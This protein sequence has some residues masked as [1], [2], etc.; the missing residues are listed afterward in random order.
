MT[1]AAGAAGGISGTVTAAAGGARLRGVH[2]EVFAGSGD[3]AGSADTGADGTY[4]V[5]GL[6]PAAPG[7]SVCFDGRSAAGGSSSTGYA[8]QCYQNLPWDGGDPAPDAAPVPVTAGR[9]TPGVDAALD[10]AGL[11]GVS[12]TVT[13]AAGGGRL[14]GVR[15]WAYTGRGGDAGSAV[16]GADGTYRV[17]GLAPP[18][19]GYRV[20]FDASDATGGSSITGYLSQC[21][22]NVPWAG[23]FTPAPGAAPVPVTAG[24][25]TPAIDAALDTAGGISGTVTAAAGGARL[26]G[27][28]VRVYSGSGDGEGSAVTGADGTYRV[29]RLAPA[30]PGYR[31]CF[32]ASDVAGGSSIT[33][34]LSQCYRN[35]PWAGGSPAP[36]AAPVPVTAGRLTPAVDAA[37]GAAGGVSGTVTAAAGGARLSGVRVEVY[38]SSGD[39]E[40][41]AATGPDGTYEVTG[42]A[43]VA[44]GYRV[45]FDASYA[46]GGSSSA[47]YFS[48]CYRDVPWAGGYS[49][50][51]GAA[52]VPVTGGRLTTVDAALNA[53][54]GISGTVT[55]AAGGARLSGVDVEVFA[56]SGDAAGSADTGADGTYEVTGLAP[57][58]PGYR[59]CF[60]ARFAAGGS[61][62]A[63]YLSQCYRN[64]PW[65]GG[66]PAPGAAPVPVTA[67]R[68]TP[69]VDA[70]LN[71]AGKGGISGTVTAAAGGARLS[72][73][74]V[75]VFT[76]SG[77]D[78][79]SAV[80]GADGTY[81]VTGLPTAT[82]GYRVCFD[83]S[84]ATGGSSHLG[85]ASQCYR[86]VPWDINVPGD[87]DS[88]A[89]GAAPVPVTAGRLAPAVDAA[90]GAAGGISGT[91][92]AAAGGARLNGVIVDVYTSSGDYE[93][94]ATTWDGTYQVTGLDPAAPGYRV[95]FDAG[96]AAV[97]S[98]HL[99]YASQCYRNVPWDEHSQAAATPVPVTAG[100]LTPAVD[101]AL[102]AAGGISGTVTAAA[103]GAR[104]SGVHVNVFTSSG[105][106][107]GSA[108]TGADGTYQVS[109]LNPAA[110]GY[111]VCFDAS[112]ATGGSS[113]AGYLSQ[114]YRNVPWDINVPPEDYGPAPGA[115]PVPVTAGRLTPAVDAAL[116]TAGE[117]GISGTVTAAA[118][119]ARLSDVDVE[120]Y[121]GSGD[122][123]GSAYTGADGTYRVT[124]LPA[125]TPGYRVCFDG[126]D[127]TGGGSSTGYA[128]QC[129]RNVPWAGGSPAPGAAPVPVTA[130]RLTPGVD[131]AIGAAGGVS[132]TVTAAAGGGRLSGVHVEVFTSS[133]DEAGSDYTEDDG[134]YRV[135][136]LDP[137]APG[138]RICFDAGDATGGN[139][140]T[141]YSSQ[142]YRDVP[143]AGDF[144]S[145][146]PGATPVPVTGERLTT[147]DAAIGAAGGI[148]GTVTAAAGGAR[149][150]GV[151]VEVDTSSGDPVGSA[152]TGAD[153]TYEVTGLDPAAPGYIVC[154]DA[155]RPAVGSSRLGYASQCYRDV[156]WDEHSQA[157][158]TPVPVTGGRL[159]PAV[160]AALGA[161][162]GVSGTVTAA[163]GG[164]RLS[165]VHV[166]VFTGSGDEAGSA[167]T[168]AD[169]TYE[170]TG[171][172]PAAP[173]YRVC[174]SASDAAGG[175]SS[176]G[177]LG[178]CYRNVP[179]TGEFDSPAPGAAPVP[180][181]AGR[182]TPAVDAALGAAG[183]ISGT[184][185]AA[186]GGTRLNGV[187]VE[188]F[189]SSGDFEGW[190]TTWGGTYQV[191]RLTP[192]AP[193]YRV[194]FYA[195]RA[196]VGSSH[197]GYASQ[198]YRNVPWEG[199][200]P[201][202]GA[203]VPVTA[204]R[205]T[206]VDAALG[207]AGGISGTVTAAAGGAS[208][209]GVDVEVFTSS[210]D[211]MGSA[212]TGADG[213]YQVTRLDPAAPGYSVC[214]DA[215]GA[216]G[217][218]SHLGYASQ[219]YRNVP[220]DI[221]VPPEDYGPA[222]GAAPVP[223]TAGRLTTVDA[224]LGAA[225]GISGTVTAAAGGARLSGV[226]VEVFNSS[227]DHV[228]SAVTGADGTYRVTGLAPAAP[229]YSVCFDAS[230]ATGGSSHLGYFSQCY[231]N[232]PWE[233]GFIPAA[234]VTLVPVT[235]GRLTTVGAALD[236][237]GG[238][239]GTVTAAAGGA[240]LSNV[241]VEVFTSSGED[242]GSAGTGADGTYRVT[243]LAP[244]APGYR[245]CFDASRAAGG[246][247][248]AGY[249]S[250]CYRNVP[251]AGDFEPAP[252]ATP[253]PVTGGRL[254]PAVDAALNA[255]GGISGT[256]RRRAN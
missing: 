161:A 65:A 60:D 224:A 40:G 230:N 203:P 55:A 240:R 139:S 154:F 77:G 235:G 48:Q 186:A 46:A 39:Y 128:T 197:L 229:G 177:Y 225:G 165:G 7:Y 26:S 83:A 28:R 129:Y 143:W 251:W 24:R 221:D 223:V 175:S 226:D 180:V 1:L 126:S 179:W 152:D 202:P 44:P 113:S 136:G 253:V 160:D 56:S 54:G 157:A 106:Y 53:A 71:T 156:P 237:A 74:R 37:L 99:G 78:A 181:T 2:V 242:A 66:S 174:F 215:S 127:A 33:G 64:V 158:A 244:A 3:E 32:D 115:A 134:T 200:D 151:D 245:V 167:G 107:A 87:E 192:A 114:C 232:V 183:G 171:L 109:R 125:A 159:T 58:A 11:G 111:R 182:L 248:S 150:S 82:P 118:G 222:P 140:S 170:V 227:G 193:G 117:G 91:V 67:G 96:R 137:A 62:S 255:A 45:C 142:C 12:G 120:V 119:G 148:S 95:C 199:G 89:P 85:Y 217:G 163:A 75:Q 69:A 38:T 93:G 146:A 86:N 19:P 70:A 30:A 256:G 238:I 185:T 196:A 41:S 88:P 122:E 61:S 234:G 188:V 233:G 195:R 10:G 204:G 102:G 212:A 207:A 73:V 218:S 108:D 149:L 135:T 14:S 50:A 6:A 236:T 15:V 18:A 31:V 52:P 210:G 13:A 97:G 23:G 57:A 213:T 76:G 247:S 112:N 49:P 90:L 132:G 5:T 25:L 131:A 63:G 169:G 153:G 59:V 145:P 47:G 43:P 103:G 219:C 104:L 243:G 205:L 20:C 239:S 68:L 105:Y 214:F 194:C 155:G 94:S 27:V 176:A 231:R 216:A 42:L 100:R 208:L 164:A 138:Y 133:G 16:T 189:T 220:W 4:R 249:L 184:V 9:L 17:T 254:T 173:G 81:R 35:V 92:T 8:G 34:Y 190:A 162:G 187:I 22:R 166:Q 79:G 21:Y 252:R 84:S 110:P 206:T 124:G 241:D 123:A 98:S 130:G 147:V 29:T 80:T 250:Q 191:T 201:V 246:S 209:S 116:N 198:C 178:Q 144:G 228:W 211:E 172:A 168:G 121:T 36:G 72:D 141:G 51:P 101:A